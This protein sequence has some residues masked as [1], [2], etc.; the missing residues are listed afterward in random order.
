MR[1]TVILGSPREGSNSAALAEAVVES[2]SDRSPE[3]DRFKLNRLRVRGCQACFACKKGSETCVIKD[4]LAQVLQSAA[5]ADLV[6]LATPVYIGEITAQ[7]KL[8]V[9][10]TYSW[11]KPGFVGLDR[12]GKLK[13]GKSLILVVT[14]GNPDESAYRRNVEFY[15]DYFQNQGFKVKTLIA[16]GLGDE[17]VGAARP[18]LLKAAGALALEA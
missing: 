3:V 2:L 17:P 15:R 9:D 4:D 13:E 6:V 7:A 12:P 5:E 1:V 14:Q 8:F 11:F 18:D 16:A 10:R